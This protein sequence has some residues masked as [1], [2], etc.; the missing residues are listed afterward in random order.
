MRPEQYDKLFQCAHI[1]LSASTWYPISAVEVRGNKENRQMNNYKM[2]PPH[3]HAHTLQTW[4]RVHPQ[5]TFADKVLQLGAVIWGGGAVVS[6]SVLPV[7]ANERCCQVGF[8]LAS[9]SSNVLIKYTF[10]VDFLSQVSNVKKWPPAY[11]GPGTVPDTTL[12]YT[13]L[14][15][16]QDL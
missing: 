4:Q 7:H 2:H 5:N 12:H 16:Q 13:T 15:Y 10:V 14:H 1:G 11:C 8:H 9:K 6:H 3:P